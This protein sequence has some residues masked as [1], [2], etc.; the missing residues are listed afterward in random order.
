MTPRSLHLPCLMSFLILLPG[1]L[2]QQSLPSACGGFDLITKATLYSAQLYSYINIAR[3][4]LTFQFCLQFCS[5][6]NVCFIPPINENW[7]SSFVIVT[8]KIYELKRHVISC[9]LRHSW[10]WTSVTVA[11]QY[12]A[13][14]DRD[15]RDDSFVILHLSANT[16]VK[17]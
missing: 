16:I 11:N 15:E 13:N 14:I 10:W 4:R 8:D 6:S 17:T 9:C 7:T 1:G 5:F 3:Y 2:Q 12:V